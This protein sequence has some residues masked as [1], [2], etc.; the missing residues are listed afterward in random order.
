MKT[1][2]KPIVFIISGDVTKNNQ[3]GISM[4]KLNLNN[5]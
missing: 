4:C 3:L 1:V 2:T 5:N